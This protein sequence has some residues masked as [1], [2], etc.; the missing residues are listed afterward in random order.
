M[1]YLKPHFPVRSAFAGFVDSR[2]LAKQKIKLPSYT[3]AS[4]TAALLEKHLNKSIDHQHWDERPLGENHVKYAT[5]DASASLAVHL[6]LLPRPS[7]AV[8]VA[9]AANLEEDDGAQEEEQ[10]VFSFYLGLL[11]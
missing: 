7:L 4:L 9:V 5:A 8:T 11:V 3:L 2:A 6:S 10:E 1:N